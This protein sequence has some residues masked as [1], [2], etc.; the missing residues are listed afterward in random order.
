M[1]RYGLPNVDTELRVQL[2]L[3]QRE[4]LRKALGKMAEE[5]SESL[6]G[7]V[8]DVRD[9]LLYLSERIL[10]SEPGSFRGREDRPDPHHTVLYHTCEECQR[11]RMAMSGGFVEVERSEVARVEGD[12]ERVRID[13]A[14]ERETVVRKTVESPETTESTETEVEIDR[15]NDARLRR[16]VI[17]RDGLLCAN[18]CC[19]HRADHAHHIRFRSHGGRTALFNE[20]AVCSRC[21]A[22][23]HAG[24][25]EVSGDPARGVQWTPAAD[26]IEVDRDVDWLERVPVIRIESRTWDS[27][28]EEP[29]EG[30]PAHEDH[31]YEDVEAALRQLGFTKAQARVRV[32]QAVQGL[33]RRGEEVT[34][35]KVLR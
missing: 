13:P 11:A 25:L 19:C 23:I 16:K 31:A 20:V 4:V 27:D 33:E 15:P 10:Q 29:G 22:L 6:G 18:P 26:R 24:L 2:T 3:S 17:L 12:A 1:G 35:E 8:V 30:A 7:Q 32:T 28:P 34:E 14:E 5:A 9:V 21:H